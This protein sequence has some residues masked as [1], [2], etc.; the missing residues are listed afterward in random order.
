MPRTFTLQRLMLAVTLICIACA[1]AVAYPTPLT[2]YLLLLTLFAP[3]VIVCQVLVSY[4]SPNERMTTLLIALF[5]AFIGFMFA[6]EAP[7]FQMGPGP[8]TAWQAVA[9]FAGPMTVFPTLGALVLGGA[10]LADDM[11]RRRNQ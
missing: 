4:S 11:R 8:R 9:P 10:A 6:V 7:A 5:G 3:T 1:I 2:A